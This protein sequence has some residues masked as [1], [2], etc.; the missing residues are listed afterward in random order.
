VLPARRGEVEEASEV[1]SEVDRAEAV[2]WLGAARQLKRRTRASSRRYCFPLVVFGLI[3]IGATPLYVEAPGTVTDSFVGGFFLV[4]AKRLSLYWLLA[5][6]A[7]Y[8]ATVLYYRWSERRSGVVASV[9]PFVITG[10][11]L[12]ALLILVSPEG[13]A[14]VGLPSS[15]TPWFRV[16]DLFVRGLTPILTFSI[17][18]LVLA[19]FERSVAFAAYVFGFLGVAVAVNLYDI[20]N[21]TYRLGLGQHGVQ[22]NVLTAG[23][24]LLAGGAGFWLAGRRRV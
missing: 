13:L 14:L 1:A 8:V 4:N 23:A 10:S 2:E 16:G 15:L 17:G 19:A 6:A 12:F 20:G 22:A 5:T 11:A 9:R 24:F 18:L 21:L 7:G 3:T